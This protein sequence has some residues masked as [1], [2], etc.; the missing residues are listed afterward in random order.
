MMLN[1]VAGVTSLSFRPTS[2]G[3]GRAIPHARAT[4]GALFHAFRA[5][6]GHGGYPQS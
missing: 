6:S 5:L 1:T 4:I 3:S 2:M